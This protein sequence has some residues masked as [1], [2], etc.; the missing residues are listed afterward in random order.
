MEPQNTVLCE[1]F[2]ELKYALKNNA[3]KHF[4]LFH[5]SSVNKGNLNKIF[6]VGSFAFKTA[7]L[8][9]CTPAHCFSGF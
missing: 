5:F 3:M 4:Y 2:Y 6:G 9:L 1:G 8:L 7:A